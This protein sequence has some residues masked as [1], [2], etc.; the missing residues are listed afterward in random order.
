[1]QFYRYR[2]TWTL[3]ED[4][5]LKELADL[6]K[7]KNWVK[8]AHDV[9]IRI[10]KTR[11]GKQCR[12]RWTNKLKSD[13]ESNDWTNEDIRKLFEIQGKIGN[14]W[15]EILPFFPRRSKNSIKN[16]FYSTIRR[17]IR[18]FNAG[19]TEDEKIKGEVKEFIKIPEI[20]EIL[21]CEK[22]CEKSLLR[23]K[24]LSDDGFWSMKMIN[25]RLLDCPNNENIEDFGL[26]EID[27]NKS[28]EDENS[29][30]LIDQSILWE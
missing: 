1:M 12:E 6:Y 9:S 15:S 4:L 2:K 18:R 25:D 7:G 5:V 3:E 28:Y 29:P 21:I 30:P 14:K 16:F 10:N 20:R 24:K 11:T 8:I 27:E 22:S 19:K 26:L 17:N 13:A 23:E